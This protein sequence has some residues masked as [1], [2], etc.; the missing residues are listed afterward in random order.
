DS[1]SR[2]FHI[3]VQFPVAINVAIL[4]RR[5]SVADF[6]LVCASHSLMAPSSLPEASLL[7]SGEKATDSTGLTFPLSVAGSRL[8]RTQHIAKARSSMAR[9]ARKYL[10]R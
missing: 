10:S 7:P 8:V 2:K 9:P 6:C 3:Q 1:V 4:S 5:L